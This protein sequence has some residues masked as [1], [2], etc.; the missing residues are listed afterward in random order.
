MQTS[1]GKALRALYKDGNKSAYFLLGDD[2]FLQNIF[3][4]KLKNYLKN[5]FETKYYYLNETND[6]E[7]LFN[8]INSVSLFA[9]NTIS[10]IKNFNKISMKDQGN[11]LEYLKNVDDNNIL[12][13]V[14]DD[15]MI[16]N[17]FAKEVSEITGLIDTRTPINNQKIK[18]WVNY[19]F[20]AEKINIDYSLLDYLVNNFSN[21]ISTIINEVE[22]YYLISDNKNIDS[23]VIQS[24]YQSKHIKT[25]H[26]LN[27][28]GQKNLSESIIIFNNLYMNGVSTIPIIMQMYNLFIEIISTNNGY[29]RLN[30]ILSSRLPSYKKN[31]NQSEIM[32]II[33]ALRDIDILFKT[34]SVNNQIVINSLLVKICRGHHDIKS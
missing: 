12:I 23:K 17:K 34:T 11:L 5:N 27:A 4:S 2:Y 16:K 3:I 26:F 28:I 8:N 7:L 29:S 20:K 14:V 31:Y 22:K 19:Y 18:E 10:I 15:F 30:K 25:W 24:D 33:L 6:V 9:S 13:F 32:N 1:V 21:D